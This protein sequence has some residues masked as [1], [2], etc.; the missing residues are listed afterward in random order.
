MIIWNCQKVNYSNSALK[1]ILRLPNM[2]KVV[3][4]WDIWIFQAL[5]TIRFTGAPHGAYLQLENFGQ[6]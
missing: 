1:P 3:Y 2:P 4:I 5:G 6:H